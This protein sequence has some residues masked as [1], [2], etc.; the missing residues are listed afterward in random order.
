MRT[1]QW[2]S[3]LLGGQ[4]EGVCPRGLSA[5]EGVWPGRGMYTFT[6]AVRIYSLHTLVK[7]LPFHNFVFGR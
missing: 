7:T 6:P 1:I 4:E 5:Q 3:R 2:S